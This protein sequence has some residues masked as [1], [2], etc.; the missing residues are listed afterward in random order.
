MGAWNIAYVRSTEKASGPG[1]QLQCGGEN[2]KRKGRTQPGESTGPAHGTCY[3]AR[4][5]SMVFQISPKLF[6]FAWDEDSN[7]PGRALIKAFS[8][9][10][11]HRSAIKKNPAKLKKHQKLPLLCLRNSIQRFLNR[12]WDGT[13]AH[14]NI[15][16][17]VLETRT[18][19]GHYWSISRRKIKISWETEERFRKWFSGRNR[20]KEVSTSS[21]VLRAL[22]ASWWFYPGKGA[23][24]LPRWTDK[25]RMLAM[26]SKALVD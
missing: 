6:S 5:L 16:G 20:V 9:Y 22:D 25:E 17:T 11:I 13:S 14:L 23:E 7:F 21:T 4:T 18:Q 1:A 12:V 15:R 3:M 8:S 19:W 10:Y 24:G 26:W 2:G